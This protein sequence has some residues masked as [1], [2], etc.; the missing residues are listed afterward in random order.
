MLGIGRGHLI[1][2][3]LF[4]YAPESK[5]R[6]ISQSNILVTG[7]KDAHNTKHALVFI[8]KSVAD[9][10]VVAVAA[11]P[12][13]ELRSEDTPSMR[14]AIFITVRTHMS[15]ACVGAYPCPDPCPCPCMC[16]G[17]MGVDGGGVEDDAARK[18]CVAL[19]GV[20]MAELM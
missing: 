8:I 4:G 3:S 6:M 2:D 5:V 13:P 7:E 14:L 10:D 17:E 19:F 12:K 18:M 9:R 20:N 11:L 1:P 16:E 15:S